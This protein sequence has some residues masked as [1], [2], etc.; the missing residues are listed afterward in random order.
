VY[1]LANP[2]YPDGVCMDSVA[3]S[4]YV[5]EVIPDALVLDS[6]LCYQGLTSSGLPYWESLIVDAPYAPGVADWVLYPNLEDPRE[7]TEKRFS[8]T[9]NGRITYGNYRNPGKYRAVLITNLQN[10]CSISDTFNFELARPIT[11]GIFISN[12][13]YPAAP[14]T[15]SFIADSINA[16]A[17]ISDMRWDFGDGTIILGKDKLE[18]EHQYES[19]AVQNIRLVVTDTIGCAYIFNFGLTPPDFPPICVNGIQTPICNSDTRTFTIPAAS[20]LPRDGRGDIVWEITGP[21]SFIESGL[22]DTMVTHTYTRPGNYIAKVT[23]NRQDGR[24]SRTQEFPFTVYG[25]PKPSLVINRPCEGNPVIF[26]GSGSTTGFATDTI[27]NYT[28]S[29]AS[30]PSTIPAFSGTDSVVTFPLEVVG[31]YTAKLI[32]TSKNGCSDS[33]TTPFRVRPRPIASFTFA[34]QGGAAEVQAQ[35]PIVFTSTSTDATSR[36]RVYGWDFGDGTDTVGARIVKTY[37]RANIWRVVHTVTNEENCTATDTQLVDLKAYMLF[38]TAFTPNGDGLN[39]NFR[40]ITR[41]LDRVLEYRIYNRWGE[42]VFNGGTNRAAA[43]DGTSNGAN[44]PSGIY[45]IRASGITIYGE[46]LTVDGRIVLIR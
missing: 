12:N 13:C 39:D 28:F 26:D 15:Y 17:R 42:E 7:R 18:V 9:G 21:E 22:I 41:G 4:I 14:I 27:V 35:S 32:V 31:D 29:I 19:E 8:A 25:L 36:I 34:D 6:T 44:H 37:D 46:Q 38:P 3:I 11:G 1:S 20:C 43:W 16:I 5:D 40:L 23:V 24:C 45:I 10:G 33:V 2:D 30:G